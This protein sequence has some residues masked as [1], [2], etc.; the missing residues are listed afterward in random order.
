MIDGLINLYIIVSIVCTIYSLSMY[1]YTKLNKNSGAPTDAD[2]EYLKKVLLYGS[3]IGLPIMI[4]IKSI[5]F[6]FGLIVRKIT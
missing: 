1:I 5:W 3:L 2:T 6:V 4:I